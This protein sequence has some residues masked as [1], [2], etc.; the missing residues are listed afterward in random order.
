MKVECKGVYTLH[1][2]VFMMPI[3]MGWLKVFNNI[4]AFNNN[5]PINCRW[6]L[7]AQNTISYS[8]SAVVHAC[9]E[10]LER[11]VGTK[12]EKRITPQ[13]KLLGKTKDPHVQHLLQAEHRSKITQKTQDTF[14]VLK[15]VTCIL[16][17]CAHFGMVSWTSLL[18]NFSYPPNFSI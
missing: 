7:A 9:K 6:C 18:I 2:R 11:V 13:V 10:Y 12:L 3:F 1:G 8:S 15:V 14:K 5:T 17:L 4:L 16:R